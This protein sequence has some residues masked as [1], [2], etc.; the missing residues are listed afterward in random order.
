MTKRVLLV[1]LCFALVAA[2]VFTGCAP[3]RRPYTNVTPGTRTGYTTPGT[4]GYETGYGNRYGTTTGYGNMSYDTMKSD[5]IANAVKQ[6]P[7][8]Q[9]AT[10][11]VTGNTAYVGITLDRS[12]TAANT[13]NIK[14]QVA[15]V[16]RSTATGV[17][18]VYVSTDVGFM[19]RLRAVGEG[20]RSGRPITGFTTELNNIIR[21]IA[22]TRW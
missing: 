16:V 13:N 6:L 4:T 21:G 18:T 1:V 3:A 5:Q 14:S 7:G 12:T 15:Q 8:V 17:N 9:N 20:L 10:V 19:N 2:L 11:V 22:P